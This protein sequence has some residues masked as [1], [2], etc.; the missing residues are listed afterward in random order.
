MGPLVDRI[1]LRMLVDGSGLA[2]NF[3]NNSLY[4]Y[5]KYQKSDKFI[6]SKSISD[7][8]PGGFYFFHYLD[9]SNWMMYS[10]VFVVD[11]KKM[12]KNIIILAVNFNFIPLEVR[13]YLFDN[14]IVEEDFEN[15]RLL[16]VDYSGMYNELIKYG[17]EYALVEY[18]AAQIKL[19]HRISM[20][21]VP[22]FLISAHPKN[23]Y[24]PGKLF[25]IWQV[26]LKDKSKRHQE[27]MKATMD[28]FF[29]FKGE[30]NEKYTLLKSH[31]QRLQT[32]MKKYGGGK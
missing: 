29:D 5:E 8:L 2:D 23:K 16:K 3:K 4:F 12:G 25:D 14:F 11:F 22:R 15:D 18:N 32:H 17:F 19:V 21:S 1:G 10:P 20:E 30:I 27:I 13:A 31:I 28:D 24:D 7:V 26:K 6:Q 9:D